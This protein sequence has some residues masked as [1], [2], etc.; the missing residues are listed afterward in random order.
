M[1]LNMSIDVTLLIAWAEI[2][3]NNST[4]SPVK[5]A[6]DLHFAIVTKVLL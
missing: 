5:R 1:A 3:G 2:P 6:H 4:K